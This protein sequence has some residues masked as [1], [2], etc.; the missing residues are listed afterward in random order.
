MFWYRLFNLKK[1]NKNKKTF[2]S[3][4]FRPTALFSVFCVYVY[5]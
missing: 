3:N 4:V 2:Q 5:I 1:Q